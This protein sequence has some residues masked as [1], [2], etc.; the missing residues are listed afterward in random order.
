MTEQKS[1]VLVDGSSYLFRAFFALPPLTNSKGEPTGAIYGVLNML[2]KLLK[3][4]DPEHVAVVFDPKGKTFRSDMYPEYKANRKTMPDEL[5]VQIQ[6]LFTAIQAMGLPLIIIEGVE[7]DDVIGTMARQAER[8]GLETLIS[9][10][11][12]DLAQL[13]NDKITL[14]NTMS[15]KTLDRAGV[16]E[17]FGVAPEQII[18][19]LALVG[20]TSDNIPGIPKVGPKTAEKWLKEYTSLDNIVQNSHEIK[21]KVGENLRENLELLKLSKDLVTIKTDV[22][23]DLDFHTLKQKQPDRE[24]LIELYRHFEFRRWLDELQKEEAGD[25]AASRKYETITDKS[26]FEKW[27]KKLTSAEYFSFATQTTNLNA[28][29]D[30]LVGISFA[31]SPLQAAYVP[32]AHDYLGAPAQLNRDWVLQQ[33]KPLLLDPKKTVVGQNIKYDFEVLERHDIAVTAKSYDIMLESYILNSTTSRH[34][35]DSL[36]SKYLGESTIK[37]EDVAGKGAKMITFNQVPVEQAASYAAEVADVTLRLHQKLYPE[38]EREQKLSYVF[39]EIEMPLVKVLTKMECYG[40]LIDEQKLKNQS[41][42]L[43]KRIAEIQDEAFKEAEGEFNLGSPKQLQAILYE[44]MQLPILRKTPTGQPSTSEDVLSELALSYSLPQLIL[45][46]RSLSKLKSTYADA[47]PLQ[48]NARTGRVHTSYNQAVTATGRLSSTEP[49]LQNIPIRSEEGRKIRQAFIAPENHKILAADY[50]QVELRI[51]AHLSKDPGLLK[52]FADGLDVHTATASEIFSVPLNQVTSD[53]RRHAKAINFGLL[54]GMSAFGLAQQI[55]VE[56]DAAK[57]YMEI[58]FARYPKVKEYMELSRKI[59]AEQ[60]YVETIFGRRLYTP[61]INV[62]NFQRRSAAERQA[63][64]APLQG[65]AAD[66]IKRAMIDIQDWLEKEEPETKMIMQVH[67]ELVFE[68]PESKVEQLSKKIREK[69]QNAATLDVPLLVDIGI[70][71]NW[72]EAH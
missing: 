7:A 40:V 36:A 72:D 56:T 48:I 67:D 61:E 24:Q 30:E 52:A 5:R 16:I 2:K 25:A 28:I 58:Y 60:G 66:I 20:D 26:S 4:Y 39:N 22:K 63:I 10:G 12:K 43:A 65:T 46:F 62:A 11:D 57:K 34:D 47:L 69:M 32:L 53:Q 35:M 38:I 21:G 70:G 8:E 9:T 19:Y 6:P 37:H 13:V 42:T 14:V 31:V 71:N 45:E 1:L 68:I 54:Y 64:N 15:D 51:V 27:L 44:K 3:D 18:D 41:K 49:N 59:A 33:L 29:A 55:G 17:K 50:S 23:M